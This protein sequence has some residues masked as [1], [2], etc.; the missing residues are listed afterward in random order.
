MMKN[1]IR[2]AFRIMTLIFTLGALVSCVENECCTVIDTSILIQ[3]E[4]SEGKKLL[5][6]DGFVDLSKTVVFHKIDGAWVV[7][8][9]HNLD[10]PNGLS[11]IEINGEKFLQLHPSQNYYSRTLSE[12]RINFRE[13]LIA[14]IKAE[15]NFNDGNVICERVWYN[16]ELKWESKDGERRIV[17]IL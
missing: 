17:I 13:D 12:T 14:I 15:F 4:D 1:K 10:V 16:D 2:I 9:S 6:Q 5:D 7:H 3:Y 8:N 11:M